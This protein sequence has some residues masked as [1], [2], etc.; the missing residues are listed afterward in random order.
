MSYKLDQ[1]TGG[2]ARIKT[3]CSTSW[4]ELE[5]TLREYLK[6]GLGVKYSPAVFLSSHSLSIGIYL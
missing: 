1:I 2:A 5:S 4:L 6:N 3:G